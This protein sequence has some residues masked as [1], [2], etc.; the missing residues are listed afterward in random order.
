MR[1][2]LTSTIAA[3]LA[4]VL[5]WATSAWRRQRR[6]GRR[7]LSPHA[8]PPSLPLINFREDVG[9]DA[10]GTAA[11]ASGAPSLSWDADAR[12]DDTTSA[13]Y[14]VEIEAA[15]VS[16]RGRTR[17]RNE[18]SMLLMQ[19]AQLYAVADGIGG[20]A[21]GDV[22]SRM[23][24]EALA[25][26]FSGKWQPPKPS[27]LPP[28]AAELLAAFEQAN[29]AINDASRRDK[30]LARMGTTLVA[31]RFCSRT[32]SMYVAHVGDSRCYRLRNGKLALMTEDH[33]VHTHGV[34]SSTLAR[35]VGPFDGVKPDLAILRVHLGDVY[36]LCSDG[37]PRMV[38]DAAIAEV[39]G[40]IE[41]PELAA[42]ALVRLANERGGK[43]NITAVVIH[44]S[45]RVFPDSDHATSPASGADVRAAPRLASLDAL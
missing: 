8:R 13:T 6:R 9:E 10:D 41:D 4:V 27:P 39:L 31:A 24:V 20:H 16:D 43:D 38:P 12:L 33:I 37:L 15:A 34:S 5:G 28:A 44:A 11:R 22:A 35:A 18:D 32:R 23:A 7:A 45:T 21:G 29:T 36:L 26:A 3:L 2:L 42:H 40:S 19:D 1:A 17:V 25:T 30:T 14:E